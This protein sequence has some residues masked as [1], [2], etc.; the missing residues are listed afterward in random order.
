MNCII[1]GATKGIGRAILEKFA[2]EGANVAFCARNQT[3]VENTIAILKEQFPNIQIIGEAV[4]MS[5]KEAVKAFGK[6]I[7]AQ[8]KQVDVLVNNVG[9]YKEGW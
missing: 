7:L 6:K 8:W 3:D 2:S 9:V 1:T 4:D 5:Q